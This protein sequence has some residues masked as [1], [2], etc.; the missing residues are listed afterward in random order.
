[1]ATLSAGGRSV[2]S[3]TTSQVSSYKPENGPA[4]NLFFGRH[5]GN[6]V[7]VQGNFVWNANDLSFVSNSILP[8]GASFYSETRRSSQTSMVG[9]V[10]VFFRERRSLLRPHLSTGVGIIHL[11]SSQQ[12]LVQPPVPRPYHR[13]TSPR[14]HARP[15]G[16][17]GHRCADPAG[18]FLSVQLQRDHILKSPQ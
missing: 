6:Y 18:L 14:T 13:A 2:V 17:C 5:L 4:L 7:S 16:C 8:Q 9:D 15:A 3:Q 11:Q 10:L 1:M 12:K